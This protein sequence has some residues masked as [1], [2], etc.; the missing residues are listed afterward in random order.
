MNI[1]LIEQYPFYLKIF[2]A[3]SSYP[4]N[5]SNKSRD[6]AFYKILEENIITPLVYLLLAFFSSKN[7][8]Q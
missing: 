4:D 1:I 8:K 6:I 7:E 2:R 5:Q 3:C